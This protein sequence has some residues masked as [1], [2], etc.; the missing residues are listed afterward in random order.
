MT[1]F[2]RTKTNRLKRPNYQEIAKDLNNDRINW[3]GQSLAQVGDY[4]YKRGTGIS[5]GAVGK[6]IS[7]DTNYCQKHY[8][9]RGKQVHYGMHT[10]ATIEFLD[11]KRDLHW[12]WYLTVVDYSAIQEVKDFYI[13]DSRP[14]RI[15]VT[16]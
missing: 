5:A 6:I 1:Y 2:T 12:L 16:W 9:S 14:E 7:I 11:G 8:I 3:H 15:K 4:V 13:N 10:P